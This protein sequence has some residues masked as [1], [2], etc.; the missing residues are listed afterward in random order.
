MQKKSAPSKKGSELLCN[1]TR[2][3]FYV[4][5]L[6]KTGIQNRRQP[7]RNAAHASK[8]AKM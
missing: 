6:Q 7:R 4:K 2:P 5:K 8:L 3:P 1:F